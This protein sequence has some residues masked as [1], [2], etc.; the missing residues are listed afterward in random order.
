MQ[1]EEKTPNEL[2][3]QIEDQDLIIVLP[4]NKEWLRK[5]VK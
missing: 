1:E 5:E 4:D 2:I 3:D